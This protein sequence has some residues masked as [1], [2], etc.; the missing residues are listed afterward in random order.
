M[1]DRQEDH[2]HNIHTDQHGEFTHQRVHDQPSV[3]E[4]EAVT[5]AVIQLHSL[6]VGLS[7]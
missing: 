3:L 4:V 6:Q 1:A 5:A 2:N 7:I